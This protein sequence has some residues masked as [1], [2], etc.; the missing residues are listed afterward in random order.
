MA[1]F[2]F[3]F[4]FMKPV[5]LFVRYASIIFGPVLKRS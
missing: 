5:L 4:K 3:L 1:H 2:I